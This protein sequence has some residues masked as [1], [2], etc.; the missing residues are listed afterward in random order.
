MHFIRKV[1]GGVGRGHRL[2]PGGDRPG[3]AHSMAG[4]AEAAFQPQTPEKPIEWLPLC[5]EVSFY[6]SFLTSEAIKICSLIV[7]KHAQSKHLSTEETGQIRLPV[8]PS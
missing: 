4:A 6:K 3:M 8:G 2:R 1:K 7:Q 5:P